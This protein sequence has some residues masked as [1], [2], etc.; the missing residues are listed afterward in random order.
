MLDIHVTPENPNQ[1]VDFKV[2]ET[3]AEKPKW[4]I[5][6][7]HVDVQDWNKDGATIQDQYTIRCA[8]DKIWLGTGEGDK[9]FTMAFTVPE[10]VEKISSNLAGG[11]TRLEPG[12]LLTGVPLIPGEHIYTL[13]YTLPVKDGVLHL[14]LRS[15]LE[16]EQVLVHVPAD[17]SKVKAMGLAL[18][19]KPV[20]VAEDADKVREYGAAGLPAGQMVELTIGGIDVVEQSPWSAK[21][22]AVGG[23]IVVVVIGLGV[24]MMKP[25]KGKA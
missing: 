21:N 20:G 16:I 18:N 11:S 3:P 7:R 22:V 19:A 13:A 4:T 2:Y 17:G 8:G 23:A 14:A 15:P 10:E 6:L 9:R 25:K 1:K 5:A 12:S 24:L